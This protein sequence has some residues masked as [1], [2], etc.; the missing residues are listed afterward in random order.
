MD[1]KDI[2]IK[3]DRFVG[4]CEDVV[5]KAENAICYYSGEVEEDKKD[6]SKVPIGNEKFMNPTDKY[7]MFINND[8]VNSIIAKIIKEGLSEKTFNKNSVSKKLSYDF[9]A[10][11]LKTY[12]D[13]LD[14]YPDTDEFSVKIKISEL[15]SKN[16]KFNA[17]FKIGQKED[18][19]SLDIELNL[20]L[21]ATVKK[22]VKLNLCLAKAEVGK[23]SIAS[24]DITIKDENKLKSA[25]VEGFDYDK[26]PLCLDNGNISFRDYYSIISNVDLK[27]EGIYIEGNHLYQ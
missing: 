16:I 19:F 21:K 22:N 25:I 27:D 18:A 2:S 13:K 24:G 20:N 6:K 8:L 26:V 11:S 15:T 4:F 3:L 12:F 1:L 14:S 5:G 9:T 17:N 7:N 23:V 10:A